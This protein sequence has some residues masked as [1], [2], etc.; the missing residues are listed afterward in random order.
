METWP[1]A[2]RSTKDRRADRR[3]SFSGE[4][5]GVAHEGHE[6]FTNPKLVHVDRGNGPE[7]LHLAETLGAP[8]PSEEPIRIGITPDELDRPALRVLQ[9][10]WPTAWIQMHSEVRRIRVEEFLVHDAVTR[11][12]KPVGHLARVRKR[13]LAEVLRTLLAGVL[14]LEGALNHAPRLVL[15][16]ALVIPEEGLELIG[17]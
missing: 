14:Q 12:L 1:E 13:I 6:L 16:A 8:P 17:S 10:H 15:L 3:A 11:L 7:L 9:V 2:R 5:Q 4:I